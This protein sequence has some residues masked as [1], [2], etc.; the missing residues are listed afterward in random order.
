MKAEAVPWLKVIKPNVSDVAWL[1]DISKTGVLL[2]VRDRLLPGRRTILGA[3]TENEQTERIPGLVMRTQLVTIA[4]PIAPIYRTA[5]MFE[6]AFAWNLE[7]GAP[8][9]RQQARSSRGVDPAD[10]RSAPVLFLDGPL[11]GLLSTDSASE[12][13][14]VTNLSETCPSRRPLRPAESACWRS[15]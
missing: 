2:D 1:V 3:T 9:A 8:D 7:T 11:D 6:G 4:G 5:L 10:S 13:A 14:A 12:M 15:R